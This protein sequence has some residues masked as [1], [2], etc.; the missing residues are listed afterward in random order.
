MWAGIAFQ[1]KE[2]LT[3]KEELYGLI[4]EDGIDSVSG[5]FLVT[6]ENWK[7]LQKVIMCKIAIM[8]QANR[9]K[10]S[11]SMKRR[12]LQLI[13]KRVW[14]LIPQIAGRIPSATAEP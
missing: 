4:D 14:E 1:R 8:S 7:C 13:N 5:C 10:A 12:P 11:S 9:R 2:M 6:E 3:K